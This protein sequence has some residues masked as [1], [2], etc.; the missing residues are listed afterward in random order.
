[1]NRKWGVMFMWVFLVTGAATAH[2]S[3]RI[4]LGVALIPNTFSA[5]QVSRLLVCISNLNPDSRTKIRP[6][7]LFRIM[8][9][10]A[11]GTLVSTGAVLV[12]S[13]QIAPSD[14]VVSPGTTANDVFLNYVGAQKNFNHGES[15][16][17][18]ISLQTSDAVG[19]FEVA[20]DPPGIPGT[21]RRYEELERLFT[22]GSILDFTTWLTSAQGPQGATG[23]QGP[24][25]AMGP[26]GPQGPAGAQG[27]TGPPGPQGAPG[28]TGPQGPAG[29]DGASITFRGGWNS[30]DNYLVNHVA[31]NQ[32]ETWIA[33]AGNTNSEPS[34]TN[35]DWSKLAAKGAAGGD[36]A[37]GPQGPIGSQGQQGATGPQGPPG[38]QGETGPAGPP[39]ATGLQGPAGPAGPQGF[40]GPQGP[41]G[42][43]A[44]IVGGGTGNSNLSGSAIR[45]VPAFY[46]NVNAA[47]SSVEQVLA[48]G[49]TLSDL[50]VR[51][52]GSPG[53]GNSYTFTVRNNG[54]D[55]SLTCA[56][57][58]SS[59]SCSDTDAAH[60]VS[61]SAG[62]T[63][64]IKSV[65]SSNPSGRAMR[66]SAK[67]APN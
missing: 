9:G 65:P 37:Q 23:P 67:F 60:S 34:D 27:E 38:P 57:I 66:W 41:Q 56:I 15:F 26:Q 10:G 50:H 43:S 53:T 64:S 58:D 25:G 14:F 32:G 11:G 62:D 48:I 24:Q 45:F 12:D 40:Q 63:V 33:V 42:P 52:E 39:G 3:S 5:G 61:F 30:I 21:L 8:I 54:A 2:G 20:V 29:A 7:D 55:T 46:S 31:T 47:E 4:Q 35:V 17:L 51:L 28:P 19:P 49:G 16:C 44:T 1:M 18:E 13:S 59:V 36:G 22:L 6:G